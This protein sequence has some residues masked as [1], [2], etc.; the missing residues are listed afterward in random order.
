MANET[1]A[2]A[3]AKAETPKAEKPKE[4]KPE[5]VDLKEVAKQAGVEPRE[6]RQIL[7][8]LNIRPEDQKRQ[9]WAFPPKDA[10][11]MVAK[12]KAA[13]AAKTE[14]VKEATEAKSEG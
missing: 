8:G 7:R 2:G 11:G 3:A 1:K 6:A 12:I 13:K 4:E 14:K 5:T 9:R 10:P